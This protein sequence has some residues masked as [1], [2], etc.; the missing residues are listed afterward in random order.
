MIPPAE[1]A[2]GIVR[3]FTNF[4]AMAPLTST[5]SSPVTK[6]GHVNDVGVKVAMRA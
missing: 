1:T 2:D 6:P 5:I 4:S 3:S